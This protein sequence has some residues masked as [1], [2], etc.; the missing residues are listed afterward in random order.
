M[1]AGIPDGQDVDARGP[2]RRHR[3]SGDF[4]T[5]AEG[6]GG[7]SLRRAGES[8][9]ETRELY[10][11]LCVGK[12]NFPLLTSRIGSQKMHMASRVLGDMSLFLAWILENDAPI[13]ALIR[14]TNTVRHP[15]PRIMAGSRNPGPRNYLYPRS[16]KES[17]RSR[18]CAAPGH[19]TV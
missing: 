13:D 17:D 9:R 3:V 19:P 11:S 14:P 8:L 1:K 4:R 5:E 10:Q 16:P 15:P 18:L 7:A 2:D 12:F 6:G